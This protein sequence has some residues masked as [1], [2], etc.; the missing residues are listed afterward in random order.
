ML[1][2]ALPRLVRVGGSAA[3]REVVQEALLYF[4]VRSGDADG[5]R[6]ILADRLERRPSPLDTRR[7]QGLTSVDTGE[8]SLGSVR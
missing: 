2:D 3:Q 5:A 1:S 6:R 4:L 8:R 7:L